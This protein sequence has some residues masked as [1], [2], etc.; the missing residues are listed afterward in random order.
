[1]RNAE[2]RTGEL[3]PFTSVGN[4]STSGQHGTESKEIDYAGVIR[5][6]CAGMEM[7]SNHRFLYVV[8]AN[9]VVVFFQSMNR[10]SNSR[11]GLHGQGM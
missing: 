9:G 4:H 2:P 8:P 6:E 7:D 3:Q 1:M 5:K 10:C 11:Q